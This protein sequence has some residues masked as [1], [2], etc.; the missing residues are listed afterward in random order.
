MRDVSKRNSNRL[1]VGS[2]TTQ[3]GNAVFD[4]VN[5]MLITQLFPKKFAFMSYYQSSESLIS[6]VFNLF[7]GVVADA[8]N[9]KR[10]L[11]ITDVLSGV[12][13]L[14][15]ILFLKSEAVF[16]G[17]IVANGLLRLLSTFN[18]PV[19]SAIIKDSIDKTYIDN[20]YTRSTPVKEVFKIIAPSIGVLVWKY[21]GLTGAY[22]F[23]ALTFFISA[24]IENRIE[25]IRVHKAKQIRTLNIIL[26]DMLEGFRYI[27]KH[28]K[29]LL[30]L[31]MSSAINFLLA[32]YNLAIP[33]LN[34]YYKETMDNYF[35][36]VLI[37][38]S[39]GSISF[40][41]LKNQFPTVFKNLTMYRSML[42]V[43]L[44]LIFL[45]AINELITNPFV[46][47]APFI[48]FSGFLTLFNI[49]FFSNVQKSVD[50]DYI[51]RVISVIFTIA[52]IFMPIGSLVFGRVITLDNLMLSFGVTGIGIM[53]ISVV[54]RLIAIKVDK[55]KF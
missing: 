31:I 13:C 53:I 42:G 1:I 43:G 28:Q 51:G 40:S 12:V 27:L 23:N 26:Q 37:A 2:V 36:A 41:L 47:L 11:I 48:L 38:S 5:Q 35:G 14:L 8:S 25:V 10:M 32:S 17:L 49:D 6:A 30:L 29:I 52:I 39:V 45:T 9:R 15:S 50:S 55:E 44:S 33:Y 3:L 54:F 16:L 24:Y 21:M 18:S 4:Y 46:N 22:L 7:A 20:H 34:S 19:Y